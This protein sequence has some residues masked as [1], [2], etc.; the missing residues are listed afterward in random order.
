MSDSIDYRVVPH[1]EDAV[2]GTLVRR[3]GDGSVPGTAELGQIPN[4]IAPSGGVWGIVRHY[5][6]A[7]QLYTPGA[8]AV[9]NQLFATPFKMQKGQAVSHI[10]LSVSTAS[11]GALGQ[12]ALYAARSG[13][14]YPTTL[15]AES[16][17]FDAS[18]TGFKETTLST[19]VI[20]PYTGVYWGVVH[21]N[22]GVAQFGGC[23]PDECFPFFGVDATD[24]IFYSFFSVARTY[25]V[26]MPNPFPSAPAPVLESGSPAVIVLRFV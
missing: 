5:A 26:G 11:G 22:S 15:L 14:Y 23:S 13:D 9:L 24:I 6:T 10:G 16:G 25:A 7:Y 1:S 4:P 8:T 19:V 20:A 17:E 12:A 21:G 3:T 2:P 18:T